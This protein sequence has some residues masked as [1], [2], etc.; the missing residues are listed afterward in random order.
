MAS[1]ES[2]PFSTNPNAPKITYDVYFQEKANFAGI[3]IASIL[4]GA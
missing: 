2:P 1:F 4:Y 3:L